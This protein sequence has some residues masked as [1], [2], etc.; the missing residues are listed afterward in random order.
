MWTG[1]PL[2]PEAASQAARRVDYLYFFEVTVLVIMST[3]IFLAIFFFAI[4]YRRRREDEVPRPIE[5]SLGLEIFWSAGPLLVCLVMFGWATATYFRNA[6]PPP[7]AMEI[8]VT[9][10]QWM[11]KLQHPEGRREINE[12]HIPVGR[13]VRL[14]MATEDVI[15][16]F[17][18]PAF[19]VKK[20]VVPGTY[21]SLWFIADK[22]GKHHLF[23]A[24]YC[25]TNHS[26]M[27][28]WVYVMEP[29][30]YENW[31]SGGTSGQS[32]VSAGQALFLSLGCA[33][34]H[35]PGGRC[36]VLTGVY[37]SEVKLTNG[38]TVTADDNYV[39]ES[40]LYPEAKIVA[41]FT[42]IM[43]TFKGIVSE[44][45]LMQLIAYVRSLGAP[46]GGRREGAKGRASEGATKRGIER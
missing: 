44:D 3:L 21:Q 33:N 41:G 25:G 27:I 29:V 45:Q 5:G 46:G 43:P 31:L 9:G 28:G 30:D 23:C 8:F 4:R 14:T 19:R 34:C 15:H 40:I 22:P 18:V 11:W 2:F 10:K 26:H 13:A 17:Y 1:F 39:R 7:D 16:S 37:G 6:A 42:N 35:N 24:E 20:D 38:Q 12:L 32:M 36:P